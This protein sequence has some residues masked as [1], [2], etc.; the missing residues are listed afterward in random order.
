MHG[1]MAFSS[2]SVKNFA[3]TE[4]AKLLE[5]RSFYCAFS[6]F[7]GLTDYLHVAFDRQIVLLLLQ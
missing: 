7:V 5:K 6:L 3:Y 1:L 2:R 4:N